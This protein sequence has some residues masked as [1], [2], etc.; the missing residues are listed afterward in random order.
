MR[1]NTSGEDK[2]SKGNN[3]F[4]MYIVKVFG[5]KPKRLGLS[6]TVHIKVCLQ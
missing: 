5:D 6:C 4:F 3:F 1:I 2:K